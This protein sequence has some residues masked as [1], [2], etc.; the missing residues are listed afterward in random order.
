MPNLEI[1]NRI[2]IHN[3]NPKSQTKFNLH[4]CNRLQLMR[5]NDAFA[6]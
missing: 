3:I 5:Q 4:F 6:V 1:K 2:N